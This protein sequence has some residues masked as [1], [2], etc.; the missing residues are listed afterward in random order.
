MNDSKID[1]PMQ[2]KYGKY[3]LTILIPV[4]NLLLVGIAFYLKIIYGKF[5]WWLQKVDISSTVSTKD[6]GVMFFQYLNQL[7]YVVIIIAV[8]SSCIAFIM[9]RFNLCNKI[10]ANVIFFFSVLSLVFA[11]L[12][13]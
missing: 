4:L 1:Q 3:V 2:E 6:P 10:L 7:Y 13:M 8:I 5:H 12:V 11:F 9:M